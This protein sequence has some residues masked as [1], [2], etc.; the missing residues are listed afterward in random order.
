MSNPWVGKI[1]WRREW[2]PIPV[3]LPWRTPM[4]R[5]ALAGHRPQS[6][7]E[8]DVTECLTLK[9]IICGFSC[10]PHRMLAEQHSVQPDRKPGTSLF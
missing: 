2:Q 3:F 1:S 7:K 9:H 5:R 10:K 4:D 6:R 8:S